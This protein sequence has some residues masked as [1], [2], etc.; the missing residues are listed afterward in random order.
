MYT[1]YTYA[2]YTHNLCQGSIWLGGEALGGYICWINFKG[3]YI[4]Y[5]TMATI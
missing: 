5:A 3:T 4:S 1:T 2:L